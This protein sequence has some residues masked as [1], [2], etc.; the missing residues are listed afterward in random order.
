MTSLAVLERIRS[1]QVSVVDDRRDDAEDI[2]TVLR[3]G[4][5]HAKV[6]VPTAEQTMAELV[7]ALKS[8]STAVLCD[9]RLSEHSGVNYTGAQLASTLNRNRVPTVLFSSYTDPEHSPE[10]RAELAGLP[11]YLP[12]EELNQLDR[13]AAALDIACNEVLLGRPPLGR[14]RFSTLVRIVGIEGSTGLRTAVVVIPA[15]DPDR[16][17]RVPLDKLE[18]D[19]MLAPSS[20]IGRRYIAMSNICAE[21]EHDVFVED[22]RPAVELSEE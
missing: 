13:I 7:V 1:L 20:F 21:S 5:V 22:A 6:V 3:F 17:V 19:G 2:R 4:Q 11:S 9:H 12:R 15:F 14:Q 8:T 10:I 18:A 16:P